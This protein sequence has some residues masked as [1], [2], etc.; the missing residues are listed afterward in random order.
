MTLNYSE[1]NKRSLYEGLLYGFNRAGESSPAAAYYG[2]HIS[3]KQFMDEVHAIAAALVKHGVKKGDYVTIFLPNIPQGV[4]AIYAVNRIGAICNMVHPLS[5]QED[6]DY[7][8]KLTESNVVLA[9]EVNEGFLSGKNIEV[10]RCRTSGYFPSTPKGFVLDKGFRF[11]M[12]KYPKVQNVAKI[13]LWD[14]LVAEGK[15]LIKEGFQLPADDV[16]P[17][18]TAVI[19]YTGGT[20]G[21]SKGVMLSNYAVNSM[22]IQLLI[23]IG[24]GKTDVGDGFLAILP[25]FH[26]FGLAVSVHAPLISGMKVVLVPRFDPK[27]CAQQIFSEDVLF[28]PGVPALFERMYPYFEQRDLSRMKLM[29]S[30]GDRVSEELANKYNVLLKKSKA[31]ILFR[32]GYGLTEACGACSLVANEYEKLPT[33]CVGTPVTGTKVCVVKPGTTE[34]VPDGVEG[35]L[36]FLG[37]SVMKG[38]YKNEDA[39]KDVLRLHDDGNVWLHTGDLVVIRKDGNIC[40]RSRHKRLVKVNGYNVYP[41]LIE[42]AMQNHPD[43]K[44]VCAVATPW[45]LD[46]KIKLF[47]VP[48]KPLGSF[49]AAEE[50]KLL[51]EYAKEQM[52]RWSVPVKVEFVAD[53]PMTKF[54]KIDYRLLEKQELSRANEKK[55]AE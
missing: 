55:Q 25:I 12:R 26:A 8:I 11:V 28:L 51:I 31:D 45:K 22:S 30:G 16:K 54:N 34:L 46:R 40:F 50:E 20:T 33:G 24:D 47:V 49:D 6:I 21:D 10:I 15:K 18:D 44:Q 2:R 23:D 36:C 5:P 7:A 53:L 32:T 19:M 3:F 52:N 1:D 41:T 4:L 14:D 42:E 35:E 43:I 37:P 38:Y 13:T 27:G 48:E 9:C 39:T 29:V 17:D